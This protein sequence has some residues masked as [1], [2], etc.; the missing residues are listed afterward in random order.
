VNQIVQGHDFGNFLYEGK[1]MLS[2]GNKAGKIILDAYSQNASPGLVYTRWNTNHYIFYNNFNN[3]KTTSASFEYINDAAQVDLKAEYFL[4]TDYLY[5]D[6]PDGGNDAQPTQLDNPINLLK[7]TLSK[8]LSWWRHWHFDNS[9]VYQKT[10]YQNT[11]RTPTAYTYSSLYYGR[12]LFNVLNTY[13]GIDVRYNTP[14][15]APSYAVGLDEFYNGPNITFPSYP[16]AT[17]FIKATLYR[18]NFFI[19]YDYANQGLQSNG[20]YTVDRYPMQ[21]HLLKFGVTWGFFN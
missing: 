16:V 9:V 21:D 4:I 11:L 8:K 6:A 17:V 12:L 2:G 18:T 7:I 15:V 1:L 13:I 5:F 14:Y 20:F 10:D 3:Q 19:M